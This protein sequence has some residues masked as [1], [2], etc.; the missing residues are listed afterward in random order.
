MAV[1]PPIGNFDN[2]TPE[3]VERELMRVER[4]SQTLLGVLQTKKT[5]TVGEELSERY[6]RVQRST[7]DLLKRYFPTDPLARRVLDHFSWVTGRSR[8][9]ATADT[10]EIASQ[11]LGELRIN[12]AQQRLKDLQQDVQRLKFT[13]DTINKARDDGDKGSATARPSDLA[14]STTIF[15]IMPFA[16]SFSD[17]WAGA[18]QRAARTAGY[19]PIRVDMINRSSDI[20]EDVIEAINSCHAAIV[21]VTGSNANVMFELGYAFAKAKPQIII[22]QSTDYLPFDIRNLRT[23]VY[24]N[25]WSGVEQLAARLS[26][27]LN[28]L[29]KPRP[30]AVTSKR[31][32]RTRLQPTAQIVS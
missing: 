23:V 24:R 3:F 30:A 13:I 2:D 17:V 7:G 26:E 8:L 29:P 6:S 1:Q 5:K 15:V 19:Q 11:M 22:S 9:R 31:S 20:T 12:F 25:D 27:F 32:R 28:E 18:I 16:E 14:N 21:D 10:L 4:E